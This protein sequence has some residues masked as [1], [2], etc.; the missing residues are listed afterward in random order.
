MMFVSGRFIPAMTMISRI[1]TPEDRGSF[2]NLENSFRQVASGAA[3]LLAGFIIIEADGKLYNYG[4]VGLIGI[5]C[6]IVSILMAY[7]LKNKFKLK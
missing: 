5:A 1:A 6:T 7:S 3:A 4:N 2:M